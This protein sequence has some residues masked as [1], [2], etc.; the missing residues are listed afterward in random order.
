MP[1]GLD[2][3]R[4]VASRGVRERDV[5]SAGEPHVGPTDAGDRGPDEQLP[6]PGPRDGQLV[7]G[8]RLRA[9]VGMDSDGAHATPPR[10][11]RDRTDCRQG[12]L[13]ISTAPSSYFNGVEVKRR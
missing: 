1:D 9:A 5:R 3:P 13:R 11:G 8:Q 7:D 6:R 12:V 2:P 4:D 10:G